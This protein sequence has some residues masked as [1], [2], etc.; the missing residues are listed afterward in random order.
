MAAHIVSSKQKQEGKYNNDFYE[1][2]YR[3]KVKEQVYFFL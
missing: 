2:N 3:S 1:A